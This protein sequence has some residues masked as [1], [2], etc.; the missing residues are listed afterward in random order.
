MLLRVALGVCLLGCGCY[1]VG[2]R[3]VAGL[4]ELAVPLF[5]N[6]TLRRGVEHD[7]T[8]AVRREVLETTPLPL[9]READ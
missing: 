7:L 2:V 9:A 4:E 3:P 6:Q 8:R 1:S 5:E